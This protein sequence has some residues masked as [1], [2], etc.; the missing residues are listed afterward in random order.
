MAWLNQLP[1]EILLQ[2]IDYL[3]IHSI[4]A[5]VQTSRGWHEFINQDHQD[6]IYH[7][8]AGLPPASSRDIASFLE[9][10][11][12]F[13]RYF[14]NVSTWKQLCKKQ[15]LLTRNWTSNRPVVRESLIHVHGDA[16]W[17]FRPDLKNRWFMST[18]VIG[19]IAVTDMDTGQRLWHLPEDS[20]RQ[21]AHLEYDK[22]WAVWDKEENAL[23]IWKVVQSEG[24]RGQFEQVA[25]LHHDCETRGF[26][27]VYPTLCVVSTQGRA[28][29]YDL[30]QEMP[31]LQT[32]FGIRTGA[33]GHLCQEEAAVMYSFGIK[34]YHFHSKETGSLLGILEPKTCTTHVCH[35]RHPLPAPEHKLSQV[36]DPPR[37][38]YLPS[39][40]TQD[41]LVRLELDS[42]PHSR[43]TADYLSPEDDEWGAGALFGKI[44]VGV[45][46]SGRLIICSDWPEAIRSREGAAAV[47]TIIE[48]EANLSTFYLGG[49]L[50]INHNRVLFEVGDSLY[51]LTLPEDGMP[52]VHQPQ[53]IFAT[54]LSA[55]DINIIP[56]SWMGVFDDCIMST[57]AVLCRRYERVDP[58]QDEDEGT[59]PI[60][61]YIAKAIRVMSFAPDV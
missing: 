27:L 44:M 2:I 11:P 53:P 9:R 48:C 10:S 52:F 18:S 32:E 38:P 57:F 25:I 15:A 42:G 31:R 60:G 45:S 14:D 54:P 7:S 6:H 17:R 39:P 47:S 4:A 43:H 55:T 34:G 58:T 37:P 12:S 19:G 33:V 30:S 46:K 22:G 61:T 21:Y 36:K 8:K 29:V 24:R 51:I 26:H 28:F 5:L 49:W 40:P 35:I 1:S 59:Y 16:I 56:A 41:R 50:S 20:V 23:E 13:A 3:P